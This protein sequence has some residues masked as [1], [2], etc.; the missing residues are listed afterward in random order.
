M[1]MRLLAAL[2]LTIGLGGMH[3]WAAPR[4]VDA[5][6]PANSVGQPVQHY[7]E[8][9]LS[10]PTYKVKV[11]MDVQVPMRD[12]VTVSVDIYRPDAPGRFPAILYRTPYSNNT[13]QAIAVSKWF[14][15]RG[16]VYMYQDVR[17]R[18]DSRGDWYPF[19]HEPDDGYDM[20]AWIGKQPWFGGKLGMMGGSYSGYTQWGP[21]IRGARHLTAL[22]PQFTTPDI[23]G[24][25][26]YVDGALNYAFALSWGA[27]MMDGQVSQSTGSAVDMMAAY[28]TLPIADAPAVAGHRA[29]H[30][31]DWLAHPTRDAYWDGISFESAHDKIEV[32]MLSVGG[33]YDIFLR[34]TLQDDIA[35]RA[36]G[37]PLARAGKRLMI[38][39]WIHGASSRNNS[40]MGP[41]R[42]DAV[43]FGVA[44]EVD[45]Q[46]VYLRWFDYWLKGI[47]NGVKDE[48][49]VKI[50]V[51]GDNLWRYEQEWPLQRA[52]PTKYYLTSD[53]RANTL[54]GD[55]RLSTQRP[56]S[57]SAPTDKFVYDPNDPVPTTGGNSCCAAL[58]SV[59]PLDQRSVEKRQDVL[60]FTTEPLQEAVE[61]TGPVTLTLYAA[62]T[63]KDTDWTA[64]LVDVAP[65]GYAR[66]VQ[67]GI[68]RARY[69]QTRGKTP[70][71]LLEPGKVYEYTIDLWSTSNAFL[72]GHRIRLEVSSSNFPHF[73]RNLNTGEDPATGSRI[74]VATQTIHHS[75]RYPSHLLLPIV[76]RATQVVAETDR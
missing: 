53:G 67:E 27:M 43:D 6:R 41:A 40:Y 75:A 4:G 16:Y 52:R 3:T 45:M 21:A 64:K 5:P 18:Y 2:T 49:P 62:T 48:P 12:G 44:A 30:Y 59:G 39:P 14:A 34:G 70:G 76:P 58:T 56:G 20:D 54:D 24:N 71:S 68:L 8:A 63:E 13:E 9:L 42:P 65:D 35:V 10:K 11:E 26:M 22:A 33:W 57:R 50:F 7:D 61:V 72:P 38:G 17:G 36:K 32:P 28:R 29:P 47:D 60:V 66:N 19:R 74:E 31:H 23:H 25:W 1:S 73:D 15:E 51:M 69:R 37:Q 55:G 46:K